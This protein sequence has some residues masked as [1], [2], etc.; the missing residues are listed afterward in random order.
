MATETRFAPLTESHADN[1]FAVLRSLV[2]D[3]WLLAVLLD[4]RAEADSYAR[5]FYEACRRL[6]VDAIT[7]V[8][9]L[10]TGEIDDLDTVDEGDLAALRAML[11]EDFG[12]GP[13]GSPEER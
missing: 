3:E 5:G 13:A 9:D 12:V 1:R 4:T 10:S 6:R 8:L 2:E 11:A 7:L